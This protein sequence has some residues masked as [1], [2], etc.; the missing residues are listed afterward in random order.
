MV[1]WLH[2]G[3]EPRG[4]VCDVEALDVQFQWYRTHVGMEAEEAVCTGTQPL[5]QVLG[6]G[7]RG[8]ESNDTNLLLDLRGDVTH[9]RAHHLQDML[10]GKGLA[11]VRYIHL[12][13]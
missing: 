11:S 3:Y 5:T 10:K 4:G 6:V 7:H 8:A 13:L 2:H 1:D 9:S 12:Q